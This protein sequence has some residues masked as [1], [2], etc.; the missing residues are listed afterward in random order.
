MA[1]SPK[2]VPM[3]EPIYPLFVD[4]SHWDSA[5]DY[6]AVKAAGIVGVIYKATE[7]ASYT[8]ATYVNQRH[9]AKAAGL[10]WGAYHF[11]DGSPVAKQVDNFLKFVAPDPDELFCLDWE[12]N[13]D[14]HGAMTAP[15]VKTWITAVE[16][17]LGREGQCV[18]YSGNTAKEVLGDNVDVFLGARRLWL[19]QYGPAP[20]CQKSWPTYWAWQFTDGHS[21]PTPHSITGIGPCDINSYVHGATQL[22]AEWAT[23][24]PAGALP[25]PRVAVQVLVAVPPGQDAKVRVFTPGAPAAPRQNRSKE[26]V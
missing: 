4:L 24:V 23:G 19:C 20:K 9:A 26:A 5:K 14:G 10:V 17:A 21:G 11:A 15:D 18:L 2:E 13:P 3:A 22:V 6:A 16:N 1:P 7:G 8:D 12:D 25:V